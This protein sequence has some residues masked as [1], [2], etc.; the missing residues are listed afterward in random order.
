LIKAGKYEKK[1]NLKD[2]VKKRDPNTTIRLGHV[3]LDFDLLSG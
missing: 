1:E 2:E 3:M